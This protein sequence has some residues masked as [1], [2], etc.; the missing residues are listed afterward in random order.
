MR[1]GPFGW[2][3]SLLPIT[4]IIGSRQKSRTWVDFKVTRS[5]GLK[6]KEASCKAELNVQL[7]L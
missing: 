1:D 4:G 3:F 5:R 2:K 7:K 6:R